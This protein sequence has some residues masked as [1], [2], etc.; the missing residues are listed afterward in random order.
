MYI[1]G[2]TDGFPNVFLSHLSLSLSSLFHFPLV[3]FK[4]RFRSVALARGLSMTL[5]E[6]T[7]EGCKGK[8]NC[9]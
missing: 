8:T 1:H 3:L 4:A 9:K 7:M 2:P 5:H 6:V